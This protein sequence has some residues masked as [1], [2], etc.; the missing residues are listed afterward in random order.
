MIRSMAP[1][2]GPVH[3]AR[4][5]VA[6]SRASALSPQSSVLSTHLLFQPDPPRT[7]TRTQPAG[8]LHQQRTSSNPAAHQRDPA[9]T[10]K[11]RD[12]FSWRTTHV[13]ETTNV[14]RRRQRLLA[15][16]APHT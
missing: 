3:R 6:A 13:R 2:Y 5:H 1:T 10:S 8:P 4:Q 16:R 7:I 15:H 12:I 9:R 14:L 11:T